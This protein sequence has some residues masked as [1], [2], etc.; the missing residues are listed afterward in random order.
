[1][2]FVTDLLIHLKHFLNLLLVHSE[3]W[4]LEGQYVSIV[5]LV[6]YCLNICSLF[7]QEDPADRLLSTLGVMSCWVGKN[8]ADLSWLRVRCGKPA[9]FS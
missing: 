1:M 7:Q 5:I 8:T 3:I 6:L 4:K 9:H 2:V